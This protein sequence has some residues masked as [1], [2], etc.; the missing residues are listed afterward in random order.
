MKEFAKK[1]DAEE[2]EHTQKRFAGMSEEEKRH[3]SLNYRKEHEGHDSDATD[4][5][6][7]YKMYGINRNGEPDSEKEVEAANN[8]SVESDGVENTT[9]EKDNATNNESE[10]KGTELPIYYTNTL[11]S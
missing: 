10:S 8:K 7:G 1:H 4:T 5:A 6:N 9:Y 2:E 3:Q 11:A